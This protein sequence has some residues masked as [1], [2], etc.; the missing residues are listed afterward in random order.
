MFAFHPTAAKKQTAVM[1]ALCQQHTS[2]HFLSRQ[3]KLFVT[4]RFRKVFLI[5]GSAGSGGGSNPEAARDR[6]RAALVECA[7]RNQS[8]QAWHE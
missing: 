5:L 6:E 2:R 4:F 8:F 3:I 7:T 1:S